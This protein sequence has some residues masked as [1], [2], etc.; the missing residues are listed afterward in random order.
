[1]FTSFITPLLRQVPISL[2]YSAAMSP[3]TVAVIGAGPLGLMAVKNLKEEGFEVTA[4][5]TRAW[6]GGL[7]K[8]SPD[9]GLSALNSTV[10]NTSAYRAAISDYPLP[11]GASDFPTASEIQQYFEGY[12]DKFALKRHI[13]FDTK[14]R[15]MKRHGDKWELEVF[16]LKES[17]TRVE[18]FDKVVVASGSFVT[19]RYP[20]I[21]G[22]SLFEGDISHAINFSNPSDF[23]GKKVL[24]VGLHATTQDITSALHGHAAKIYLSH[25]TGM[26]LMSRYGA[27]GSTFDQTGP[28]FFMFIL[29]W[30]SANFPNF[31]DWLLDYALTSISKKNY[32]SIPQEWNFS[33]PPSMNVSTPLIADQLYPHL[34]SGFAKPVSGIKQVTGPRTVELTDGSVLTDIDSII[35]CTGYDFAVPIDSP[36]FEP[37]PVRGGFPDLYRGIFPLS[38]DPWIRGSLAYM[39]HGALA[40]PGFTQ[41]ELIVMAIAQIWQ[42]R[43]HLPPF[44]EQRQWR[45]NHLRWRRD[46]LAKQK[47]PTETFIPARL[48]LE[49]LQWLD[50]MAGCGVYEHFGWFGAKAWA[51][52]WRDRELYRLCLNGLCTPTLFRLFETGK[53]KVW[54]GARAQIL[55]DNERAREQGRRKRAEM[56]KEE[57]KEK[58]KKL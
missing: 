30:L 23:A 14:V 27:D 18:Y 8:P 48:P 53:R 45:E 39:G 16:Q 2:Q 37:Y 26:L 20:K 3:T 10:F 31:H 57:M 21:H 36:D 22:I 50:E 19:P 13:N 42:G 9:D 6:V 55:R 5:E 49:Q 24:A 46:L 41:H 43:S 51:F 15:T 44:D 29:A 11:E 1:M 17:T 56:E 38:P 54:R 33:N 4:Y 7:W 32:P 47:V 25:R 58:K 40:F 35:Y 12:C 52:W 34:E 28:L